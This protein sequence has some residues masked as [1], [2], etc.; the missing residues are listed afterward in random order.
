MEKI[1]ILDHGFVRLVDHMGSELSVVRAARAS[2]D[3]AC[4]VGTDKDDAKLIHYLWSHGH[5]S[6]FEAVTFTFEIKA[7]I[8]VLRQWPR[9]RTWSYN[10]VY[11]RY[12]ELNEEYYVPGMDQVREQSKADKQGRGEVLQKSIASEA[13][14]L[15][16]ITCTRSFLNYRELLRMGVAREIARSVL[17]VSA[18]SHMF[19]TVNLLNLFRFLALR[20]DEHVQWEIRQY[21]ETMKELI[22]PV[23]PLCLAAWEEDYV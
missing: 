1:D 7:P 13:T 22:R 21:A 11:A 9:Y 17:P 4:R 16:D 18:Y 10:E 20:C 2:Y 19:A 12:S 15:I 8:F 23:V 14:R 6:P 3:A 5:T